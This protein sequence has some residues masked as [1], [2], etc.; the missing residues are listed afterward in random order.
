MV[1]DTSAVVAIAQRESGWVDLAYAVHRAQHRLISAV[2]MV[3]ASMVLSSRGGQQ[4]LLMLE[5]L[6]QWLGLE[7][8]PFDA[9]Q[10]ALARD[11]FLR[12]GKGRHK[13]R[14][15]FG[16]CCAYALAKQRSEPL[17]YRGDDFTQT[18]LSKPE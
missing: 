12:F 7:I 4:G 15:N 3:E 14:L 11:A 9:H 18:D 5:R 10:A 6:T 8:E 16:D 13:A 2:S 17:L 1:L